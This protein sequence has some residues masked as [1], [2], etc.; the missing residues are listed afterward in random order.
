MAA[1]KHASYLALPP[2]HWVLLTLLLFLFLPLALPDIKTTFG[3]DLAILGFLCVTA[4]GW[5]KGWSLP[6]GMRLVFDLF[7]FGYLFNVVWLYQLDLIA[8]WGRLIYWPMV[9]VVLAVCVAG[10]AG[11]RNEGG[12]R[13]LPLAALLSLLGLALSQVFIPTTLPTGHDLYLPQDYVPKAIVLVGIFALFQLIR[14]ERYMA[15]R[16]TYL[17]IPVFFGLLMSARGCLEDSQTLALWWNASRE[18]RSVTA[19]VGDRD[20]AARKTRSEYTKV[21]EQIDERGGQL[22]RAMQ[23]DFLLRFR[24]AETAR[25]KQHPARMLSALEP[26]LWTTPRQSRLLSDLWTV[27]EMTLLR[28]KAD[29]TG[30]LMSLRTREPGPRWVFHIDLY[31]DHEISSDN[32]AVYLLDRWGRVFRTTGETPAASLEP[33]WSAAPDEGRSDAVN[34]E[35]W[36]GAFVVVFRN[37]DIRMNRDAPFWFPNPWRISLSPGE[38]LVDIERHPDGT[39]AAAISSFGEFFPVG[40]LPEG[41]P[42]PEEPLFHAATAAD[43][44][45]SPDGRGWYLL[46]IHGAIHAL[47]DGERFPMTQYVPDSEYWAVKSESA[48]YWGSDMA[49]DLEIDPLGR[50]LCILNRNGEVWTIAEPQFRPPVRPF[51]KSRGMEG[52]GI[53]LAARQDGSLSVLY[54]SGNVVA[55]P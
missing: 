21:L 27:S 28:A 12:G 3:V 36:D 37:G 30:Y 17:A 25:R 48:P 31:A 52:L 18:E 39:G 23:W 1:N 34:L 11:F 46:D 49:L 43:L 4:V 8:N 9:C 19:W 13:L 35:L 45:I 51:G 7:V 53:S 15:N 38:S 10:G 29:N 6:E 14:S 24:L 20:I 44:E 40:S 50:G 33:V 55:V 42:I 2:R 32:S 16:K 41:F 47:A 54:A 5:H 22:S 26:R